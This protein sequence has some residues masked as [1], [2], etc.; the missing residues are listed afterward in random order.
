M[1]Y[2]GRKTAVRFAVEVTEEREVEVGLHKGSALS[3]F[4]VLVDRL[5][6]EVITMDF[7]VCDIVIFSKSR[8][9]VEK[10]LER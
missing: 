8:K 5:M 4:A 7:D 6:A 3:L 9:Q 2:E 10:K 1:C